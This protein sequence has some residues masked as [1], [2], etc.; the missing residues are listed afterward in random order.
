MSRTDDDNEA[1][2]ESGMCGDESPA[3][4]ACGAAARRPRARFCAACGRHLRDREY[5]PA[6]G[7]R[8]SYRW[9][10]GAE[11]ARRGREEGARTSAAAGARRPD[12]PAPAP[13]PRLR[14]DEYARA[15]RGDIARPRPDEIS[16]R[17]RLTSPNRRPR[18]SRRNVP[19][20]RA[21]VLMAYALMPYLGLLFAPAALA[22]GAVGLRRA[23]RERH[24]AAAREAERA[25][26]YAV[27]LTGAQGLLW[28]ISLSVS[29]W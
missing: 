6:E 3:C 21:Y 23:G 16:R 1:A 22:C 5:R 27:L 24:P 13:R 19:T 11:P 15:G 12:R 17:V 26:V 29:A 28:L 7:L 10:G 9:Q 8:A 2:K 18:T 20:E 14:A 25:V 4:A